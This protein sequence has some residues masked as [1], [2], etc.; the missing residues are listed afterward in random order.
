MQRITDDLVALQ[1]IAGLKNWQ[2]NEIHREYLILGMYKPTFTLVEFLVKHKFT[3][4]IVK[5]KSLL[6]R[7][8][9]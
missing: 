4:Y 7:L 8:S 5:F 6:D 2:S 9:L 1:M 3:P